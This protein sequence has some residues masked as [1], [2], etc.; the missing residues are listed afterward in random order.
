MFRN[1]MP[2]YEILSQDAMDKLDHG[3]RRIVSEL[4]VEFMSDRALDVF[5]AAGQRVEERTVFF[6]PDFILEQVA[7]APHEFDAVS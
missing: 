2:R 6:D 1:V 3:W 7:K 5:R 4:G